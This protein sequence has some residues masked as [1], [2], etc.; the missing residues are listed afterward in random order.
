MVITGQRSDRASRMSLKAFERVDDAGE[1]T[2]SSQYV[3]LMDSEALI[4][5]SIY[6]DPQLRFPDR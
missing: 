2:E 5:A 6:P 1:F 3:G 4:L